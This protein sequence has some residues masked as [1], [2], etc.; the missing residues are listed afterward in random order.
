MQGYISQLG[1]VQQKISHRQYNFHAV[2]I[3]YVS[4]L[5]IVII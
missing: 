1:F 2:I 4:M 5:L 3:Y